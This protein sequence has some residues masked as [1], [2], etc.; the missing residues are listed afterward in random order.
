[1][2]RSNER[3]MARKPTMVEEEVEQDITVM[4]KSNPVYIAE[5]KVQ[6]RAEREADPQ[7]AV[8][9]EWSSEDSTTGRRIIRNKE[10][11]EM[12]A[13]MQQKKEEE[14]HQD[15]AVAAAA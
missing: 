11:M 13:Q 5:R 8:L 4:A 12:E 7:Q 9:E 2:E 14:E 15:A 3:M 6:R 1:M 10:Q